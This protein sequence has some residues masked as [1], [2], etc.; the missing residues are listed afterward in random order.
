MVD[1]TYFIAGFQAIDAEFLRQMIV[2]RPALLAT[3]VTVVASSDTVDGVVGYT[4]V[5]SF[6]DVLS[7]P[8]QAMLD[9]IMA[10]YMTSVPIAKA[11][12]LAALQQSAQDYVELHY[13][14]LT[15]T[16]LMNLYTLAKFDSLTSRAAYIRPGIDWI[17]TVTDYATLTA[18]AINALT[19]LSDVQNYVIDVAGNA[20]TDPLLTVAT[21]LQI[22]T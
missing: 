9:G 22:V 19:V 13:P 6:S 20:G 14:F 1:S 21:A 8:N 3:F 2:S 12:K 15:R 17:T 5:A 18:A 10:G 7:A 16:Q 11:K 4:I